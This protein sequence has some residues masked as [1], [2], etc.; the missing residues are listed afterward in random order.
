[1]VVEQNVVDWLLTKAKVEDRKLSFDE[2]MAENA[3]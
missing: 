3:Q 1:M 2:L